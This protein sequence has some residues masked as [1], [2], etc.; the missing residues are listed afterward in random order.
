LL[1]IHC[2][3]EYDYRAMVL[4]RATIAE[5]FQAPPLPVMNGRWR[6]VQFTRADIEML[7]REQIIPEDAS[8]ELLNGLIVLT[9]RSAE[10]EDP[11]MVGKAHRIA[12]EKLSD[13]RTKLNNVSRHVE[14]QQPL[15]CSET[16]VPQPDFMVLRGALAD[17]IDLPA[18]TDAFCVV[19]VADSSYERDIGEKLSGY[20]KANV[21]QYI[22]LNLRNRTAEVYFHPDAMAGTYPVPLRVAEGEIL[23][24]RIGDDSW[25][26]VALT[27]VLP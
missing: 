10:G 22:V 1:A 3:K 26:D 4:P 17:Y 21:Q 13:L 23:R 2:P 19:E 25:F 11:L 18:A 6:L 24:L 7:L 9:D 27:H 16:H 15:V 8:T 5:R 12:V 20:A 14:T